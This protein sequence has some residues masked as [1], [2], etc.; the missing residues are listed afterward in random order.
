MR[1][2]FEESELFGED[3]LVPP[4]DLRP[5]WAE[6]NLDHLAHN[7]REIKGLLPPGV[8]MMA[9][10]KANAY[11]H[12]AVTVA[13]TALAHGA[14]RLAV[15]IPE[16]GIALRRAG[17]ACPIQLLGMPAPG[18]ARLVVDYDLIPAVSDLTVARAL[19]G[20]AAEKKR[21]LRV[22]IKVDTG[23][24]R[25]GLL[26]E[27]VPALV[28]E[29]Q[30]LP[31]LEIE[32]LFTHLATADE[33]DKT[34]AKEQ[35]RRF[36]Q[37]VEAL[38]QRGISIPIKHVAN[39]AAILDLPEM[40]EDMVRPGIILYGLAPS[41]HVQMRVNLK[42]V[43][44]LKTRVSFIKEVPPGTGISYGQTYHT[45][46]P[47]KIAVLPVG[48]ADGLTRLLSGKAEVLL[49]GRRLPQVGRICMDQCM[50][51]VPPEMPVMAGDEAV[52][53][54][55]QGRETITA[56]EVAARLGT[57]NYEVVCMIGAR[58]P[59]VYLQEGRV[60]DVQWLRWQV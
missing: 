12:G 24:G 59:R 53:I 11:G 17:I 25:L 2:L 10:V 60:V 40:Y 9:V 34:L 54:G 44:S 45:T 38:E 50:V 37:T 41:P 49:H 3:R 29:L 39:S 52:L 4:S 47:A 55:S 43:L 14:D 31:W 46:R 32:G 30:H 36:R 48:Y 15:A 57:I 19:A 51:E 16:E 42:P 26:P 35:Y 18:Q 7:I 22:H 21:K 27:Q 8:K 58:V 6:I 13:K 5:T 33:K 23:M 1:R 28:S 56:D 20:A